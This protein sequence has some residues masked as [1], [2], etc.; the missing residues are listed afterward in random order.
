V[1]T[2]AVSNEKGQI[3]FCLK[4]KRQLTPE[5]FSRHCTLVQQYVRGWG[6]HRQPRSC[7]AFI[8]TQHL[9]KTRL[10]KHSVLTTENV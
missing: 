5:I 10:E 2:L 4:S 6:A 9:Q 3:R 8:P 7:L 1:A